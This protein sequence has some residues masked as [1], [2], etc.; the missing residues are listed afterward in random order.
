MNLPP[1]PKVPLKKHLPYLPFVCQVETRREV[2]KF[3]S[4]V[5]PF[6]LDQLRNINSLDLHT[7][8]E[9]SFA[10]AILFLVEEPHIPLT[11]KKNEVDLIKL[12]VLPSSV[13]I[14]LKTVFMMLADSD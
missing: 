11:L 13:R 2:Q 1:F 6:F 3:M 12:G 4:E 8:I 9:D 7:D 14:R 10:K 5:A